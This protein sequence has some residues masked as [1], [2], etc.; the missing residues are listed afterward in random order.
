MSLK[1]TIR[2]YFI[3]PVIKKTRVNDGVC[4]VDSC[5]L[6]NELE[7]IVVEMFSDVLIAAA[8]ILKLPC[9]N[10]NSIHSVNPIQHKE[11]DKISSYKYTIQLAI[12]KSLLP[13]PLRFGH[14]KIQ[15]CAMITTHP[16]PRPFFI[17]RCK[18]ITVLMEMSV[19]YGKKKTADHQSAKLQ[20]T[21][22]SDEV[23]KQIKVYKNKA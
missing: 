14:N 1:D 3:L 22:F 23:E 21:M 18:T 8:T 4:V 13:F 12:L 5:F 17:G 2:P 20:E 7:Y 9:I 10:Q 15:T 11:Y 16:L 6:S 19:I